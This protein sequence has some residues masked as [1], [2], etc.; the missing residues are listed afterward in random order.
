MNRKHNATQTGKLLDT[1]YQ[2]LCLAS[3]FKGNTKFFPGA[4]HISL[5]LLSF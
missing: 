2:A 1:E 3:L 4:L 5:V